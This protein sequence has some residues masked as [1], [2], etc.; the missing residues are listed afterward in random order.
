MAIMPF[1][2]IQGHRF[3]YQWKACMRLPT[4]Q[5]VINNDLPPSLHH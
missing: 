4:A 2:V 1:N 5:Q 3:W